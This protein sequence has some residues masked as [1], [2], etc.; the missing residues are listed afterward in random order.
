MVWLHFSP[1]GRGGGFWTF[2]SP[3]MPDKLGDTGC[4]LVHCSVHISLWS[5]PRGVGLST[6]LV[7]PGWKQPDIS[8]K[9]DTAWLETSRF[10]KC[11]V[12]FVLLYHPKVLNS[13]VLLIYTD[14]V[15]ELPGFLFWGGPVGRFGIVYDNVW[16]GCPRRT[17]WMM[18]RTPVCFRILSSSLTSVSIFSVWCYS[19]VSILV[20]SA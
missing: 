8:V 19:S 4:T 17:T 3:L 2:P 13:R 6:T 20:V 18:L 1:A 16:R 9:V 10:K 11:C 5:Q 15:K 12:K 7:W 14:T